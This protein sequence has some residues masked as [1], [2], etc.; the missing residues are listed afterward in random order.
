MDEVN[1]RTEKEETKQQIH[2]FSSLRR[3][4]SKLGASKTGEKNLQA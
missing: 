1:L 3:P 2:K 4:S